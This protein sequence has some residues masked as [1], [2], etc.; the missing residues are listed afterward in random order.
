[1]VTDYCQ[2]VIGH[3]A[4]LLIAFLFPLALWNGSLSLQTVK[5]LK[6]KVNDAKLKILQHL[7]LVELD[8]K[9]HIQLVMSGGSTAV[10][11]W[12]DQ[13]RQWAAHLASSVSVSESLRTWTDQMHP[14]HWV[15]LGSQQLM[16]MDYYLCPL[17]DHSAVLA[18]S[19]MP[20]ACVS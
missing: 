14:G 13:C 8:R 5:Q 4:A 15:F 20:P 9:G 7:S 3:C 16:W 17:P 11:C 1:M 10:N 19:S 18:L 6:M 12:Q 2:H